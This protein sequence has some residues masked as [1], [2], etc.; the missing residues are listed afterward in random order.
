MAAPRGRDAG[1]LVPE[2]TFLHPVES[3]MRALKR[4]S[5]FDPEAVLAV[6][7]NQC[8]LERLDAIRREF[9]VAVGGRGEPNEG[10]GSLLRAS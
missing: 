7:V 2:P 5:G 3:D 6:V 9:F 4:G 1:G 10:L 8:R